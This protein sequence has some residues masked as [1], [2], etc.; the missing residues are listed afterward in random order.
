MLKQVFSLVAGV[1]V[2]AGVACTA[3]AYN[4]GYD[5]ANSVLVGNAVAL[6]TAFGTVAGGLIGGFV[7][8]K[9]INDGSGNESGY[10][11]WGLGGWTGGGTGAI[12]AATV[13]YQVMTSML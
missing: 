7:A 6:S 1:A 11:G 12:A 4:A 13:G 9:L 10:I 5:F 8:D 3:T 2:S